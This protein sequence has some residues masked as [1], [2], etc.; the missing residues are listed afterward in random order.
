MTK[1]KPFLA[2]FASELRNDTKVKPPDTRSKKRHHTPTTIHFSDQGSERDHRRQLNSR[3]AQALEK[4]VSSITPKKPF[5]AKFAR[6]PHN[7]ETG[8][9]ADNPDDHT[10]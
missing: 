6:E 7:I 4:G 2:R 9:P 3:R 1:A 8:I 10:T 5:L